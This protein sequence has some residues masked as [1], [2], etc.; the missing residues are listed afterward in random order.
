VENT[1]IWETSPPSTIWFPWDTIS[2]G[3]AGWIV[4]FSLY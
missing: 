4:Y 1:S 2:M 3:K